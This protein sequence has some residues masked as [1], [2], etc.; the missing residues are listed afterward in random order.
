LSKPHR[1]YTN[2][3][4]YLRLVDHCLVLADQQVLDDLSIALFL[5]PF[6]NA[7]SQYIPSTLPVQY[8]YHILNDAVEEMG[9]IVQN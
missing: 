4:A 5:S 7:Y 9:I 1:F 3:W 8:S 2:I 6:H